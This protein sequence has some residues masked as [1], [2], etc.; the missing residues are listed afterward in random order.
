MQ[1]VWFE[2]VVLRTEVVAKMPGGV[3]QLLAKVVDIFF[4]ENGH[5]IATSGVGIPVGPGGDVQH[6]FAKLGILM[7]MASCCVPHPIALRS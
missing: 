1:D 2:I 4:S 7:R 3:S 6:I 5:N